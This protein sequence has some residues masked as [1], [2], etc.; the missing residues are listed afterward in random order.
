YRPALNFCGSKSGRD[1]DKA[2]ETGLTKRTADGYVTFDEA[3]ITIKAK[4]LFATTLAEC[5]FID[6]SVISACYPKK[7]FHKM[8][9]CEIEEIEEK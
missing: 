5:D 3:R 7:D 1:Y 8:Y 9:I 6:K 2:A 4:K